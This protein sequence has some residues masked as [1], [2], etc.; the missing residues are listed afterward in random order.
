TAINTLVGTSKPS[1]DLKR[2]RED[3]IRLSTF[4]STDTRTIAVLGDSGEGKSSLINA[5]LHFPEIAKTGDI[6]AAC[7]S[8]VTEYRQKTAAHTSPITIEVE[9]LSIVEIENLIKELLWNYRQLYL[10]GVEEDS[11]DPKD[12]ARFQRESEQ[13]WSALEAGFQHQKGFNKQ[14]IGDMTDGGLEKATEKLI[15]WARDLDWPDGEASGLWKATADDAEE[16]CEMTSVFMQDRFWPFT[17]II[18][19]YLDSQALIT[20]VVPADLPGLQDTN[21]A[22]VRATQTYLMK[23]DKIFIIAKIARAITDQS[24]KSSLYSILTR[25]APVEWEESGG[26]SLNIAVVCTKSED[27]NHKA[28]RREFCGPRKRI[29]LAE[30]EKLDR[31][32]GKAKKNNDRVLKK[33]LRR[34]QEFLLIDARNAHVKEGLQQAYSFNIPGGKLEVFCVSNTTYEKYARKGNNEMV[35]G[36]GIPDLRRFCHTLTAGAQL[37]EAKHFL[38]S[39]LASLLSSV[40]IWASAGP[41]PT[42]TEDKSKNDK[43]PKVLQEFRAEVSKVV[44]QFEAD[45]KNTVREVLTGFLQKQNRSWESEAAMRGQEWQS[46]HWS[47][48]NAWCLRNGDHETPKRNYVNWNAELIWAMRTDLENQWNILDQKVSSILG[49][50]LQ[51]IQ[52]CF[53]KFQAHLRVKRFPSALADGFHPR[54]QDLS[55]RSGLV[56]QEFDRES[57][58]IQRY[59]SE[60]NQ[61]SYIL[62][63]MLPAYRGAAGQASHMGKAARQR[64]IVHGR[65]TNGTPFSQISSRI[66]SGINPLAEKACHDTRVAVN[67]VMALLVKDVEMALASHTQPANGRP[68]PENLKE[69][70]QKKELMAE[71]VSLQVKHK[72]VLTLVSKV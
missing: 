48:Y 45:V 11:T 40:Q 14:L 30:M 59:A 55:Y 23:C 25:H 65:I 49:G 20:G 2:L 21:L 57:K 18:R 8:V 16:C 5:L 66:Q 38:Q 4:Q 46:W 39:K 32:I 64:T 24:L 28:A 58:L 63:E 10:P 12:Y 29:T 22:R 67:A 47:Q 54:T 34:K 9:Y 56:L 36:S 33:Q 69:M 53:A 37:L 70:K 7:T 71:I 60:P 68:K 72:N 52:A 44:D 6:G 15:R 19:V 43:T 31:D 41:S 61:T 42:K 17:K 35:R 50:L 26:K 51:N 62:A 1:D 13:A 27:I 3:A